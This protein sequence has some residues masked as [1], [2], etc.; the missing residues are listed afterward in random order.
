[1]AQAQLEL[2]L[3]ITRLEYLNIDQINVNE[4]PLKYKICGG[5]GGGAQRMHFPGY[6]LTYC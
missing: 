4:V 5:W 6:R 3:D 2:E 1:M